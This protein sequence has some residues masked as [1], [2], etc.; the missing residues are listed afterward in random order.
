[1]IGSDITVQAREFLPTDAAV[2]P[3]E[4]V[5]TI[6]RSVFEAAAVDL[7]KNG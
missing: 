3:D 2:G 1:M 5:V 7:L 4:Q 6:P